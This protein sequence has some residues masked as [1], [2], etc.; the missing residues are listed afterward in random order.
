MRMVNEEEK[1]TRH[2][3]EICILRGQAVRHHI[4]QEIVLNIGWE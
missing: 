2:Q 4:C 3:L 1:L